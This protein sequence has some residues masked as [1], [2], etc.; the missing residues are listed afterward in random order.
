MRSKWSRLLMLLAL[1]A[2]VGGH[3]T[4]LFDHWDDT[5]HTGN[6][7]DYGVVLVAS[8]AAAA[9]IAGKS[10]ALLQR[11]LR[12]VTETEPCTFRLVFRYA[13]TLKTF[14]FDLSPPAIAPIRI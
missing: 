7:I 1:T 10:I 8:C 2:I 13:L 12:T 4:E 9:F 11:L 14:A 3:V 5:L 6:D